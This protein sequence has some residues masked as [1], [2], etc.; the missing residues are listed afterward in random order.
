MYQR[1]SDGPDALPIVAVMGD[2]Q[3]T[4]D[5]STTQTKGRKYCPV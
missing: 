3:K 1:G 5:Q 4:T 2:L